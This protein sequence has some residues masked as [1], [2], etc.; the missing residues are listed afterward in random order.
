MPPK[1]SGACHFKSRFYSLV[2]EIALPSKIL[3]VK[4]VILHEGVIFLPEEFG[5]VW[6]PFITT[7]WR[8]VLTSSG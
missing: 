5:N 8:V 3:V 1:N 4:P 2:K 6:R 7:G